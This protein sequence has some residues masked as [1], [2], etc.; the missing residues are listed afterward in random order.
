MLIAAP[1]HAAQEV[2]KLVEA[3]AGEIYC[4]CLPPDW[5]RRY[6]AHDSANRR[7]GLANAQSI[8][9][10]RAIAREAAR[11]GVPSYLA[12]NARYTGPQYPLLLDQAREWLDAGG[13]AA[14]VSDIGFMEA[15]RR[16]LPALKL[17]ASLLAAALNARTV[18]VLRAL[19]ASRVVLPRC[20]T[21]GEMGRIAAAHPGMEFEAMVCLDKC[22]FIDGLCRCH[23]GVGYVDADGEPTE[24]VRS[25][26]TSTSGFGCHALPRPAEAGD[27]CAACRLHALQDHGVRIGK[28]GGRGLPLESRVAWARFLT[29]AASERDEGRIQALRAERFGGPCRCYYD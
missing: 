6:G 23:H 19:G 21:L 28:M 20:L 24:E 14:H 22:T 13:T 4:G 29:E 12:L 5:T 9:A 17:S 3:G 18:G 15:L 26:D 7:Q 16:A 10:L 1:V 8:P 25:F 2:E 11:L 27:A